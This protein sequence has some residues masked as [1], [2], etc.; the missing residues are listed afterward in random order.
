LNPQ[1]Y[2]SSGILEIYVLGH[3]TEEEAKEVQ[4]MMTAWPE[5]RREVEAIEASLMQHAELQV[6]EP[7]SELREKFIAAATGNAPRIVNMTTVDTRTS[8]FYKYAAAAAIVLFIISAATNFYLFRELGEANNRIADLDLEKEQIAAAFQVEKANYESKLTMI[9]SPESKTVIL[10]GTPASP[11][12]LATVF[13]NKDSREVYIKINDLP[14]PPAGKQYQLWALDDG[15]P[16]D[17]GV[18]EMND[19]SWMHKMKDIV[20]A[21]AF[22]VTLET[23]GGSPVPTLT[24]MYLLGSL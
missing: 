21:Q 16:V 14:A 10:K 11:S 8:S 6:N 23:A 7:P 19:T 18:F 5:V 22:A 17:A 4:E 3:A 12:S 20:D 9:S 1:E 24:S 15:K 13:W 2:I